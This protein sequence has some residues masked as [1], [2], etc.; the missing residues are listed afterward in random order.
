MSIPETPIVQNTGEARNVFPNSRKVYIEGSR[1]NIRVPMREIL[2]S[3]TQTGSGAEENSPALVYDTSGPYTDSGI[4]I[5]LKKGLAPMRGDWIEERGNTEKLKDLSSG[6]G[7]VQRHDE[8]LEA[9]RFAC[10]RQPLRAK[11]GE[12]VTQMH[13]ARSGVVTP[14]MEFAAIRENQQR[15]YLREI[16]R[17]HPGES[18]GAAIPRV[19]TPEFVRE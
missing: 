7:R 6:Y 14:E 5:D 9:L 2:L 19:I 18:F 1:P 16:T 3:P 8:A 15:E 10:I 11:S 12:N 4:C 13:Y 17:Q